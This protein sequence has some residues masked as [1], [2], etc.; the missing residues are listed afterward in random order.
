MIITREWAMPNKNT[1]TIKPIKNFIVDNIKE[2]SK[3]KNSITIIDPFANNC[4]IKDVLE[5]E[6]PNINIVYISNDLDPSMNTDYNMDALDF[7]KLMNKKNIKADIILHDAPFTARQVSESYKKLGMSVN[8]ET[9][10]S[11]FWGNLKKEIANISKHNS[12][13]FSFGYNS[14]GIG[15]TKGYEILKILLTAHGGAHNDTISVLE[16][17]NK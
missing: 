2:Y 13:V 7:L 14:G 11:S 16:I 17:K 5:K 1:F 6:L 4:S 10:Q 9:T 15:K 8:M 12:L 3:D